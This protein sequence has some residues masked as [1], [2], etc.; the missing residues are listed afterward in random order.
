[1]LLIAIKRVRS[2]LIHYLNL[3]RNVLV[4]VVVA[5]LHI[6]LHFRCAIPNLLRVVRFPY[7]YFVFLIT[8][9]S[10]LFN[11]IFD[12]DQKQEV[13]KDTPLSSPRAN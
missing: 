8:I 10:S 9:R 6:M 5:L 13:N 3:A 4:Q 1:M 11:L 12:S 2:K 7:L